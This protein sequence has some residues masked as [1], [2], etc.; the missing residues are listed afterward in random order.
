MVLPVEV[1]IVEQFLSLLFA[2]KEGD[3][4]LVANCVFGDLLF[5]VLVVFL[6]ALGYWR[7]T[8]GRKGALTLRLYIFYH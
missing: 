6:D 4:F 8:M 1:V 5:V 3:F 2:K 7:V